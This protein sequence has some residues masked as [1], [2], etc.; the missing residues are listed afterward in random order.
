MG[1]DIKV[2]KAYNRR[3]VGVH[4]L[5]ELKQ[6]SKQLFAANKS[7]QEALLKLILRKEGKCWSDFYKYVKRRK[8]NRKNIPAIKD[9]NGRIITDSIEKANTLNFYY[10]SVFSSEGNIPNIQG[11]IS[12]ELF[13][14]DS[15]IIRKR[16]AAIRKNKSVGPDC[17]SGEILKL[18]GEAMIPYL[19]W[20]LEITM[21]NGT[22]QGDW[23]KA[24][25]IPIHKG[26]DQSLVMNYRPVS[27]TSVV[28]KLMEHV[29]ASY[30][31]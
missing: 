8:E 23:K 31:R 1:A 7:A 12:S 28:C 18:G 5:G 24:T 10:S 16:I 4:Y 2:R 11:E 19:A 6:L 27:L 25:V 17:V 3:K 20:L 22:L 13:T 14:I 29:I 9:C 30:L 21:N 15:K 26:G